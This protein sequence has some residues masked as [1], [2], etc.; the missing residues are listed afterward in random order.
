[1]PTLRLKATVA[2]L[3][4]AV[5][6][7][8]T[9]STS[10]T[11]APLPT[12]GAVVFEDHFTGRTGT[13]TTVDD[14][15]GS[16]GYNADGKL[17]VQLKRFAHAHA[18]VEKMPPRADVYV[19]VEYSVASAN[20]SYG[21]TCRLDPNFNGTFYAFTVG[22][23]GSYEII[24]YRAGGRA[25]TIAHSTSPRP[26]LAAP[27]TVRIGAYC[28][29]GASGPTI[30]ALLGNGEVLL[31]IEDHEPILTPGLSTFF[32]DGDAGPP[33]VIRSFSVRAVTR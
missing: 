1:M 33:A 27:A 3:I 11:T 23:D 21:P 7:S 4:L 17:A 15:Y 30:L 29:G 28:I 22:G 16:V 9:A 14:Q 12:L 13:W 10:S 25:Q 19:E 18:A 24:R 2:G 6:A 8:C 26:T 20:A 31:E 32:A 5:A